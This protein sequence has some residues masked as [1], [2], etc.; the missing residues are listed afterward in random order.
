MFLWLTESQCLSLTHAAREITMFDIQYLTFIHCWH[1]SSRQ[2]IRVHSV[3]FT[4]AVGVSLQHCLESMFDGPAHIVTVAMMCD[5]TMAVFGGGVNE[6]S[7]AVVSCE[8][9]FDGKKELLSWRV[10]WVRGSYFDWREGTWWPTNL[11]R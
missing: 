4:N 11:H 8:W 5:W 2:S 1:N 3:W 9:Q 10:R 6:R 7:I